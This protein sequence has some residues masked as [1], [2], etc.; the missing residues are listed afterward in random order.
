MRALP[1]EVV[2]RARARAAEW[3][4]TP[5]VVHL[6]AWLSVLRTYTGRDDLVVGTPAT[7]RDTSAADGVVGYLLSP[8]VFRLELTGTETFR[9]VVASAAAEW[10]A[11][12]AQARLPLQLVRRVAG[13]AAAE[14]GSPVQVFFSLIE[15]VGGASRLGDAVLRPRPLPPPPA[16]FEVFLLVEDG[17]EDARLVLEYQRGTLDPALAERLLAHVEERLAAAT[18]QPDEPLSRLPLLHTPARPAGA[19]ASGLTGSGATPGAL[20]PEPGREAPGSPLARDILKLWRKLLGNAQ[21]GLDDNFFDAGGDSLHAVQMLAHLE[22]V[23][24]EH[25]STGMLMQAG[26]AR[27]LA[28][29]LEKS[30][31][32]Q[33]AYPPGIV[34]VQ[35]GASTRK[36]FCLPGL[37]GVALQFRP[38]APKL[39]SNR[40][41][42]AVEVHQLD[43]Q[44]S[45]FESLEDTAAA[46]V[47]AIRTVQPEGPY[48]VL[49]YSYGGNL[50]VEVVRRLVA[51]GQHVELAVIIA[52][53]TPDATRRPTGLRKLAMHLRIARRLTVGE[54]V[55]TP[56]SG[57]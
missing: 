20:P 43:A 1:P 3:E 21:L 12:R 16:K 39:R 33:S 14:L 25:V 40:S 2:A 5:F 18:A 50:G 42:F 10:A 23:R 34:L 55:D 35:R 47:A 28:A 54:A 44:A 11:V 17:G 41:I 30:L 51:E 36:L 45:A 29:A 37:G 46:V 19:K 6:A 38:L 52:A 22:H 48:A 27:R 49:G 9:T 57:S 24:G 32:R 56:G 53:T 26:T 13:G 7:L 15:P 8:V 4:T 31:A